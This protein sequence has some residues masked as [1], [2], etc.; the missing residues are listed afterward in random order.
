MFAVPLFGLGA[1]EAEC[2]ALEPD[3]FRNRARRA[4][5]SEIPG[6]AVGAP[7]DETVQRLVLA[8]GTGS[9]Y[10]AEHADALVPQSF[11]VLAHGPEGWAGFGHLRHLIRIA[12]GSPSRGN[13]ACPFMS[14]CPSDHRFDLLDRRWGRGTVRRGGDPPP[15]GSG[16]SEPRPAV[17][18][19]LDAA[20][21]R[22]TG[23][24]RD[25]PLAYP[26]SRR[27][28]EPWR[29]SRHGIDLL[30]GRGAIEISRSRRVPFILHYAYSADHSILRRSGLPSRMSSM[31]STT[32]D[33]AI[34]CGRFRPIRS[35]TG[36]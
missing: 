30:I 26:S 34:S 22:R 3:L 2:E 21:G 36:Q 23:S 6:N 9:V 14:D 18:G 15:R 35:P 12:S 16:D 1:E 11:P 8:G 31:T 5:A 24:P 28:Q 17:I 33:R 4:D 10:R 25:H 29:T 7:V 27:F 32:R 19:L 20:P 13:L